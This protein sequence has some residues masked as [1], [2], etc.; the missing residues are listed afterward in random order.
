MT[1]KGV[2]PY[3]YM[4]TFDKFNDK[5]LPKKEHFYSLLNDEHISDKQYEHAKD[6]W[7]TFELKTMD[8]YHDLYLK[9]DILLLVYVFEN[10]RD[11]CSEYYKLDPCHYFT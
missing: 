3:D 1:K 6:V 4:D 10:F 7:E 8:V 9:S 5:Q 2:Y 11:T